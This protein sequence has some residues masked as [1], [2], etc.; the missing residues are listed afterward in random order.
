MEARCFIH[1]RRGGV[2]VMSAFLGGLG[3]LAAALAVDAGS[4]ALDARRLQGAADL[5]AM[6]AAADL[7]NAEATAALT[8]DANARSMI[9]AAVVIGRYEPDTAVAP[10]DRF[11]ADA[12]EANAVRVTVRGETPIYFGSLILGRNSVVLSRTATAAVPDAPRAGFSIGSRLASLNGGL[13]NQVLSG[14]TGSSVSL[15]VFDYRALADA[16]VNL[17]Q[18]SDALATELGVTAGDYEGL[19]SRSVT[20]GRALRVVEGLTG[21]EADSALSRLSTAASDV[22]LKVGD[23]IGVETGAED[24]LA[25]ALD[26]EVSALDLAM[27]MLETGGKDRQVALN[28]GAQTGL[29][30]VTASLAIGERPNSSAW[31]TARADRSMIVRT[32]QARL[33]LSART[34]Q[35][36]SGLAQVELPLLVELAA[37]EARLEDAACTPGESVTLGVRPGVARATL[38]KVATGRLDDFQQ[39]LTFQPATLLSVAG[40]VTVK[41]Q[42]DVEAADKGFSPL[43]FSGSEI[44]GGTVKTVMTTQIADSVISSLLG[45]LDVDVDVAGLGIGLGGLAGSLATLLAPVG[46]VLD[47]AINPLL[48]LLGLSFGEADLKVNGVHCEPGRVKLVG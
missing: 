28:L 14:L 4:V 38:G 45:R 34:S 39:P 23:L 35:K 10:S 30:A 20:A 5:A 22:D 31:M 27:A 40:L 17:L 18:F 7:G 9:D 21:T 26:A 8:A 13:A 41:G 1:D 48:D 47:A 12:A 19:L 44:G 25:E 33:A 6:A 29:A 36:L 11:V 3:C 42:A 2:A 43:V 37:S 24:A 16:E 32:A 46:P 15:T